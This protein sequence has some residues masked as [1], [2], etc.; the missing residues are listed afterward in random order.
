VRSTTAE[1]LRSTVVREGPAALTAIG[2]A[3]DRLHDGLGAPLLAR[4][5]WLQTWVDVFDGWSPWVLGVE[6]DGELAAVAPLV[7]RRAAGCAQIMAIGGSDP[8]HSPVMARSRTAAAALAA[9]LSRQ[10]ASLRRPWSLYLAQLPGDGDLAAELEDRLRVAAVAPGLERATLRI[11]GRDPDRFV[12]RNTRSSLARHRNRLTREGLDLDVRWHT[13]EV[14]I[15][16]ELPTILSI[17]RARDLDLRRRS[18]LDDARVQRFFT[19]AVRRHAPLA[20]LLAVRLGGELAAYDLCLRDRDTLFVLDNRMNPRFARF[21]PGLLANTETVRHAVADPG[22]TTVDWG[23][24][25]ARYKRSNANRIT[26][27]LG[28]SAWSSPGLR[29]ALA[30]RRAAAARL[31][32]RVG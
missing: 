8:D 28:L 2:P 19:L 9:L 4:R 23:V 30:L 27:A 24:G 13:D 1:S 11:D 6:E 29:R 17:H 21:A 20:G 25:L 22:V 31:A 7:R 14:E 3:L 18:A 5:P 32:R 10:L 26:P 15:L 12:S 16:S